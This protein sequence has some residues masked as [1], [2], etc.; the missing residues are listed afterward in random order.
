MTEQ[1]HLYRFYVHDDEMISDMV[2]IFAFGFQYDDE[3]R[4]KR[5]FLAPDSL[6]P[7]KETEYHWSPKPD[8]GGGIEPT[9][10]VDRDVAQGLANALWAAGFRPEQAKGSAGQLGA[11]K[12]HRDDLR[13]IAFKKL[14]I[15]QP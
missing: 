10:V 14:G 15:E 5:F 8:M 3:M 1:M 11:V 7:D 9:F 4:R 13:R 6:T 2:H 12:E